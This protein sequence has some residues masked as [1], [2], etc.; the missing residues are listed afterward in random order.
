[1]YSNVI[2]SSIIII[3]IIMIVYAHVCIY[4]YIYIGRERE[5][6]PAVGVM[7][8]NRQS[9]AGACDGAA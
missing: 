8:E 1:M 2:T 4:T 6:L 3:I 7:G 9:P 5:I